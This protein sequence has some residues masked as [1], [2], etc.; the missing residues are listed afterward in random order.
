MSQERPQ[1]Q[2]ETED[3]QANRRIEQ[4]FASLPAADGG[5]AAWLFLAGSFVIETLIWGNLRRTV[6]QIIVDQD[7]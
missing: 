3:D 2:F 4:E 6:Y 5:W 1:E 7:S